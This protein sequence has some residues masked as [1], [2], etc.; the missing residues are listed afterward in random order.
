MRQTTASTLRIAVGFAL[1]MLVALGSTARAADELYDVDV[2]LTNTFQKDFTQLPV[3]LQVFRAFGRGVDYGK[4]NRNG[5]HIYN[6]KGEELEFYFRQV[7][8]AF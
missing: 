5:F 3:M 4:F 6:D 1:W 7:P 2:T 8:P